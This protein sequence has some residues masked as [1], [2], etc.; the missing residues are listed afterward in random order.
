MVL[1][2]LLSLRQQLE[3]EAG[4]MDAASTKRRRIVFA[5]AG[6]AALVGAWSLYTTLQAA[7]PIVGWVLTALLAGGAIFMQKQTIKLQSARARDLEALHARMLS[8]G[9][10]IDRAERLLRN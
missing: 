2:K 5:C 4:M 7:P 6:A 10:Q 3:R 1:P 8:V 9:R